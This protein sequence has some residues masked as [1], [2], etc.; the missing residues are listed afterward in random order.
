LNIG[1]AN[2]ILSF[3]T[4]ILVVIVGYIVQR[5]L[6]D[7]A[8]QQQLRDRLVEKRRDI[9][10]KIAEDLNKIYCYISDVGGFNQENLD[11][12]IAAK[13]KADRL[14]L[15]YKAIWP[16]DTLKAYL[17]FIDSV[18]KH[19][20]GGVG[21][22]A[23]IRTKRDEK[24]AMFNVKVFHGQMPGITGSLMNVIQIMT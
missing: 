23:K 16:E 4:P 3:V 13:W 15:V 10:E 19:Y 7:Q 8:R 11:S 6:T 9:Y 17:E 18:F 1:Q 20:S 24:L 14:M 12:I 22:S 2:L 5:T 21:K